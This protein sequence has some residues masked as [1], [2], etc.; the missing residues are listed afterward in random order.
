MY[1]LADKMDN[2]RKLKLILSKDMKTILSDRIY[3]VNH[4]DHSCS[5]FPTNCRRQKTMESTAK[6]QTLCWQDIL[7]LAKVQTLTND[8]HHFCRLKYGPRPLADDTLADKVSS[9]INLVDEI[10]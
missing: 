9:T 6:V 3:R 1:I 8:C 5:F 2:S 10:V 4:F 7:S